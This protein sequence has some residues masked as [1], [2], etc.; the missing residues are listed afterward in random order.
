MTKTT[1][2]QKEA[3]KKTEEKTAEEKAEKAEKTEMYHFIDDTRPH[4]LTIADIKAMKA[5]DTL[6]VVIWDGNWEEYWAWANAVDMQPYPATEFFIH[7]RHKITYL[8]DMKWSIHFNFGETY[9]YPIHLN[10]EN[11]EK[12][13][14]EW[15]DIESDGKIHI[16]SEYLPRGKSQIPD[17]WDSIH[18]HWLE[19]PDSTRVGWR[20]PIMLW[21]KLIGM[22]QVYHQDGYYGEDS[23][24]SEDQP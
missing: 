18:M 17:G 2:I 20:G 19:F 7:N 12:T 5:G 21:D 15:C 1:E 23:E 8:G 11:L 24:D 4:H 6:D 22:P 9:D 16:T 3:E 13:F 14:C 10:T